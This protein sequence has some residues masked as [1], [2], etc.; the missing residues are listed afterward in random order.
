MKTFIFLILTLIGLFTAKPAEAQV[1]KNLIKTSLVF[2]LGSIYTL[3]YER[4][5]NFEMGIQVTAIVGDSPFAVVPEFRYYLSETQIAPNGTF[6][7]PFMMIGEEM[8]GGLM[9]GYQRL[10]KEKITLE[11]YLGPLVTGDGVTPFG[12]INLGFAF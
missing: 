10:F 9:V 1:K 2:P 4:L 12:N 5:L 8:G 11:A 6:V 3:S 7:G